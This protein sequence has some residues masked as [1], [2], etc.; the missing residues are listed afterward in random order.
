MYHDKTLQSLQKVAGNLGKA[1]KKALVWTSSLTR[2]EDALAVL[3]KEDYT[4]QI[5]SFHDDPSIAE[6]INKVNHAKRPRTRLSL[7][8]S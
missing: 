7:V 2:R 6:T 1:K 5:W 3:P 4:V 8:K